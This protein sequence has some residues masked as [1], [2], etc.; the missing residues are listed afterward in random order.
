L[1]DTKLDNLKRW[2]ESSQRDQWVDKHSGHWGDSEWILL[3][4]EIKAGP[5][6]PMSP[7]D[8]GL[9]LESVG[10]EY[11]EKRNQILGAGQAIPLANA[12]WWY[13]AGL[14]VVVLRRGFSRARATRPLSALCFACCLP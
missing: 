1:P 14:A 3:L 4:D 12:F 9:H 10:R 11:R 8:I 13:V 6:W 5:Y 2:I 7:D